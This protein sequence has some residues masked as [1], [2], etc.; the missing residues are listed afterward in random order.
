MASKN[1]IFLDQLKA[2]M[3][4]DSSYT[5]QDENLKMAISTTTSMFERICGREFLKQPRTEYIHTYKNYKQVYNFTA[6]AN[7]ININDASSF[8]STSSEFHLKNWP[9]SELP[10]VEV[11]Y[12]YKTIYSDPEVALSNDLYEID[13]DKGVIYLK[14]MTEEVKKGLK[15][16]YVAGYAD[17]VY[18]GVVEDLLD[19]TQER[20]LGLNIP[21]DLKQA[22]LLQSAYYASYLQASLCSSDDNKTVF[23]AGKSFAESNQ[24]NPMAMSLL[25]KYKR[26]FIKMI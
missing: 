15:V 23:L 10:A 17:S 21:S 19:T 7:Y 12:K 16:N 25:D 18:L 24:L 1:L 3:G 9:V 22:A 14:I 8:I 11:F 5:A 13:F 4:E 6:N 2:Y 20:A 26:R